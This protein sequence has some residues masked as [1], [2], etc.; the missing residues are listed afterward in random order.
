MWHWDVYVRRY[1]VSCLH[2]PVHEIR[3]PWIVWKKSSHAS[4]LTW[5]AQNR[6][7]RDSRQTTYFLQGDFATTHSRKDNSERKRM[8]KLGDCHTWSG[9]G[10]R[11]WSRGVWLHGEGGKF[12]FEKTCWKEKLRQ[13]C[14][15]S[16]R[17]VPVPGYAPVPEH[18]LKPWQTDSIWICSPPAP[19]HPDSK[20]FQ[21]FWPLWVRC[22][23]R[24]SRPPS[25][26]CKR[27][28][29][30]AQHFRDKLA[31][32]SPPWIPPWTQRKR[33]RVLCSYHLEPN[34]AFD[35]CVTRGLWAK[36]PASM[37]HSDLQGVWEV[38]SKNLDGIHGRI[39]HWLRGDWVRTSWF[40]QEKNTGGHQ[41]PRGPKFRCAWQSPWG[42]S[43]WLPPKSG[44]ASGGGGVRKVVI[45]ILDHSTLTT[46]L[47]IIK[48]AHKP[49][50]L[51]HL[52]LG[53]PL[54]WHAVDYTC[55][56][57]FRA[58]SESKDSDLVSWICHASKETQVNKAD[59]TVV[60]DCA[61]FCMEN[62][63]SCM[64]MIPISAEKTFL[65]LSPSSSFGCELALDAMWCTCE[66]SFRTPVHV[67]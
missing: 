3:I 33:Q 49:R 14:Q 39:Q 55:T 1:L 36:L 18:D 37:E 29:P 51:L 34:S 27:G 40:Q 46:N 54:H 25:W 19:H 11:I 56:A 9:G 66:A 35:A 6:L 12:N 21:Y 13:E 48:F 2:F 58:V 23:Q 53:L 62:G 59:L 45:C 28:A 15:K 20:D 17:S 8:E 63:C 61:K 60:S 10:S 67:K 31:L 41:Q 44:V 26:I 47:W 43:V 52:V 65:W 38:R 4:S 32:Q 5:Q 22:Q 42:C 57:G 30:S 16:C 50:A 64:R 7:H 24:P